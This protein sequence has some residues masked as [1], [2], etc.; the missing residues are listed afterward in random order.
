MIIPI[1]CED[2]FELNSN[3]KPKFENGVII[4]DNI[5]KNYENILDMCNNAVVEQGKS[6]KNSRNFIDYYDCKLSFS[7]WYGD[8]DKINKRLNYLLSITHDFYQISGDL[9]CSRTYEFNYFKNKIPNLPNYIQHHPHIDPYFNAIF[10][11]DPLR[12]GGTAIYKDAK[13]TTNEEDNML[14]DISKFQISHLIESIPNR[15]VIFPGHY[16]HGGYIKN[17]NDYFYNWR[18]N[19]VHFFNNKNP[20]LS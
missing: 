12:N 3:I 1:K 11:I 19:L 2:L 8:T 5:F 13:I 10:Y 6:N 18:I 7:N 4:I 16:L 17:H 9:S 14:V 15:C 20:H